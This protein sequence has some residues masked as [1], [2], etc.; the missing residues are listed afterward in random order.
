MWTRPGADGGGD[1]DSDDDAGRAARADTP[2]PEPARPQRYALHFYCAPHAASARAL[3]GA[4]D[5]DWRAR[6]AASERAQL[7][8][9]ADSWRALEDWLEP[10]R[11]PVLRAVAAVER[12]GGGGAADF[13][14]APHFR[15]AGAAETRLHVWLWVD[16]RE[17]AARTVQ[18]LVALLRG[19]TAHDFGARLLDLERLQLLLLAHYLGVRLVPRRAGDV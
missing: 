1:A 19:A 4:S 14:L 8:W 16:A 9:A 2:P 17:H 15:E 13:E 12:G 3:A 10:G 6:A 5:G 11:S 7:C 18:H